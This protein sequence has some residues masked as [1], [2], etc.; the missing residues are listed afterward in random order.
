MSVVLPALPCPVGETEEL[1]LE[2]E[3]GWEGRR[4]FRWWGAACAKAQRRKTV[5]GW[6]KCTWNMG[7]R[8]MCMPGMRLLSLTCARETGL[9]SAT[10]PEGN[11]MLKL[12]EV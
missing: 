8:V 5:W 2:G 4:H 7:V 3:R 9:D 11:K 12:R 1:G 6:G 10:F